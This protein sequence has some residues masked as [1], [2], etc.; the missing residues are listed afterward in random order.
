M[1]LP[2]Q[3]QNCNRLLNNDSYEGK[4]LFTDSRGFR[5]HINAAMILTKNHDLLEFNNRFF[6]CKNEKKKEYKYM[7]FPLSS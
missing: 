3:K 1:R 4:E 5:V 7:C 6:A 2:L